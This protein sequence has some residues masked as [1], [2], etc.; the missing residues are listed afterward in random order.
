MA[1]SRCGWLLKVIVKSYDEVV[2]VPVDLDVLIDE[3]YVSPTSADWFYEL[4]ES[5]T[6]R[7]FLNKKV[8]KSDLAKDP[9]F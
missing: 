5:V 3:V 9:L 2:Y 7:C 4:V 6:D 1:I 8:K